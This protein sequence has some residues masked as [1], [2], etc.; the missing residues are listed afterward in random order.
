MIF[1]VAFLISIILIPIICKIAAQAGFVD[2]PV[3]RKQHDV[4]VPPLGGA[5]I[6]S[7][8]LIFSLMFG[9]L[10]WAVLVALGLILVVGIIDDAWEV[11]AKIKFLIHFIAAFILVIGGDVQIHS[12]GNLLGFGDINLGW[13][14]IP[15]SVACV[16]YIQNAVNMMDG[17]DGLAGGNSLII[18][19]WLLIA[20]LLGHHELAQFQLPLL[21][22]CL[23]GFLVF[24]MRSPILKRA[25]IFLGDAGS[26]ALGLMIAW[27]AI[28]MSQGSE[29]VIKPVSVAWI[30]ALPIIDSFGLLVARLKEKRPP[31]EADRR[32]FHHHFAHA[33]FL[34][35][36]TTPLILMYSCILGA[37]GFFGMGLGLPEYI[38]GWAWVGL[39]IGHALL[40]IQ[41]EKFI[42]LLD[43]V[44]SKWLTK[45]QRRSSE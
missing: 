43:E 15:F 34:P 5:I 6:F 7:V 31:F 29:M 39:W 38:L 45:T 2:K 30:L 21:I 33:G 1:L 18:F 10:P 40:T 26:M 44:R 4:P 16:V 11:N 3:G 9:V 37:I 23:C 13:M 42:Q 22:A 36:L 24:N 19:G 32:H 14:A 20:G 12:L 25:K 35:N 28:A 17:V 8:F 27:A 41:S